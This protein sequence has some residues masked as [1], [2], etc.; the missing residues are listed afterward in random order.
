MKILQILLQLRGEGDASAGCALRRRRT[1]FTLLELLLAV[2]IFAVVLASINAVFYSAMRLQRRAS[3]TIEESLPLQQTV[4]ILKRDLQG[5][6][7]P[8]G[9]L[10]GPLQSGM[11]SGNSSGLTV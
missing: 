8:G 3:G 5:L 1:A 6:V 7:A 2:A 10:A 11:F 4:T 9:V